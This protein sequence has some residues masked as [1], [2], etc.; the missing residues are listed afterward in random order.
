MVIPLQED[1]LSIRQDTIDRFG[2]PEWEK[3]VLTNL[4]HG[5][6]G[7]YS[8]IGVK[9]GLRAQELLGAEGPVVAVRSFAGSIPPVS[10]LNDGLQISTGSTLGRGLIT[11]A[12]EAAARPEAEFS[13]AGKTIR[14]GLKAAYAQQ[15]ETDIQAAKA[16]FGQTPAYWQAV[17][18]A[19]IRYWNTW[20]RGL[21]FDLLPIA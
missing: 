12:P 14:L 16:R 10:C 17:R 13:F 19:A 7:I 21:I 15:I 11:L 3:C 9:M 6:L 1:I 20:D 18:E 4:I 2:I 5:H 8:L